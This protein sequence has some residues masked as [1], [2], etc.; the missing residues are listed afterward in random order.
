MQESIKLWIDNADVVT[1]ILKLLAELVM[2]RQ[3]RLQYDMQSCMAVVLFRNIAKV[4]CEYGKY[5]LIK[6]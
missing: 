4:I 6:F 2:N 5:V 3:S 1:P